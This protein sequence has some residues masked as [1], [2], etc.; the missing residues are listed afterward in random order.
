MTIR[1]LKNE[2]LILI[3]LL[4]VV[5]LMGIF[6]CSSKSEEQL[7]SEMQSNDPNIKLNAISQLLNRGNPVAKK[8][9]VIDWL[10]T[11]ITNLL[12]DQANWT[13]REQARKFYDILKEKVEVNLVLDSLVRHVV[14]P[15]NYPLIYSGPEPEAPSGLPISVTRIRTLFLTVKLGISDSEEKLITALN[16]YGDKEMAE[17]FLNSGSQKLHDGGSEWANVH[18]YFISTGMG[19]HRVAWGKF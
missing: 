13:N 5:A 4:T 12:D 9:E 2:G 8:P 19:S 16:E 18:G 6:A 10:V 7:L 14:Y 11:S 3:K 15:E 17:D 1:I